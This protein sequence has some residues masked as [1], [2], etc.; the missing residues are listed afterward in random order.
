MQNIQLQSFLRVVEEDG[1]S[2]AAEKL[3]LTQP[4]VTRHIHALEH[5]LQ[6][7]LFVR[8]GRRM[9]LTQA[10][11]ILCDY[12]R[13]SLST[14]EECRTVLADLKK[15]DKGRI[16]LGAGVTTSIFHLPCWLR[17]FQKICPKIDVVVRTGSSQDVVKTVLE[18]KV[19]LGFITSPTSDPR[20]R[21]VELF[22]D[23]IVLV[24]PTRH[25][26][27]SSPL[28]AKR[29]SQAPLILFPGG[30]GFRAYLDAEFSNAGLVP[31]IKMENDSLEAIK[32]FVSVGL[33]LS[34]LPESAVTKEIS[35]GQLRHVRVKGMKKLFRKTSV[36][37]HSDRYVSTAVYRFLQV[38]YDRCG[39][40]DEFLPK[41]ISLK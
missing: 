13:R 9:R 12:A 18:R 25:P 10:G 27:A 7:P 34:F 29:F 16:V 32:S 31:L 15:G 39:V 19:D 26:L 4:A 20:L 28:S 36:I 17:E 3:F 14:L 8:I 38:V 2:R 33:G 21:S 35:S 6:T 37:Y 22:E 1:V 23:A 41:R 24:G 11:H 40:K 5:E 30:S